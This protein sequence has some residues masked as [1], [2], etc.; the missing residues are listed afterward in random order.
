MHKPSD[1]LL[2]GSSAVI[3]QQNSLQHRPKKHRNERNR[4]QDD[5]HRYQISSNLR[6]ETLQKPSWTRPG[7]PLALQV[8]LPTPLAAVE[9]FWPHP[10]QPFWSTVCCHSS[11]KTLAKND[12]KTHTNESQ[13]FK[14]SWSKFYQKSCESLIKKKEK[15]VHSHS[16]KTLQKCTTPI[17]KPRWLKKWWALIQ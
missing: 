8:R 16:T 1:R 7:I 4:H 11:Q 5:F 17:Q 3:F 6:P 2:V 14:P 10:R 12:K 13:M 15:K 9:T